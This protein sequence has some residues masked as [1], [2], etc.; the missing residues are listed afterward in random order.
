VYAIRTG[1]ATGAMLHK[2]K[3]LDKKNTR[4]PALQI[5]ETNYRNKERPSS[6]IDF[7]TRFKLIQIE[8]CSIGHLVRPAVHQLPG[9]R[10][11]HTRR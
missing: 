8:Y 5:Q 7:V 4:L 11:S 1:H 6:S 9:R 10:Y 2:E 3:K